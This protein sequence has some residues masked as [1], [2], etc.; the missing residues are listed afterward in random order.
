MSSKKKDK[1]EKNKDSDKEK[2]EPESDNSDNA[3]IVRKKKNKKG[4]KKKPPGRPRKNPVVPEHVPKGIVDTSMDKDSNLELY[5]YNPGSIKKIG[6]LVKNI[7][8]TYIQLLSYPDRLVIYTHDRYKSNRSMIVFYGAKQHH[9]Y[10]NNQV[11]AILSRSKFTKYCDD[12]N[13]RHTCFAITQSDDSRQIN[14][15]FLNGYTGIHTQKTLKIDKKDP[16]LSDKNEYPQLTEEIVAEMLRTDPTVY[17]QYPS[18]DFK[19]LVGSSKGAEIIRFKQKGK[20]QPLLVELEQE[21]HEVES[22]D[23]FDPRT[24]KV[25]L[26]SNVG[27]DDLFSISAS[28]DALKA[29]SS[30]ALGKTVE[31]FLNEK[32]AILTKINVDD[33][34]IVVYTLT[35]LAEKRI[36]PVPKSKTKRKKR[37]GYDDSDED[38]EE[39]EEEEDEDKEVVITKKTTR[40][41]HESSDTESES[42]QDDNDNDNEDDGDDD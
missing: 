33:G 6:Q 31:I 21:G 23:I 2:T 35:K 22:C 37:K 9:Y 30:P 16:T 20:D 10:H 11:D 32:S 18:Y 24:I 42:E 1:S 36:K 13:K 28:S 25:E 34:K 26:K 41:G 12:L 19:R 39:E 5:Y 38:E 17:L 3:A 4:E 7:G 29:I 8:A 14:I 40:K 15:R 27:P